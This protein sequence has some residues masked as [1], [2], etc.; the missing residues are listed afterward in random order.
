MALTTVTSVV[1]E[2]TI[3]ESFG[4]QQEIVDRIATLMKDRVN[5]EMQILGFGFDG[6]NYHILLRYKTTVA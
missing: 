3:E 1:G 5:N 2:T 6:T 4:T